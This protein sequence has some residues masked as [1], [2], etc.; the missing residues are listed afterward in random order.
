MTVMGP[1]RGELGDISGSFS[2]HG[3][4]VFTTHD[5]IECVS[6]RANAGAFG[7]TS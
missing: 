3:P 1:D 6:V 4:A 5:W 2:R 7:L